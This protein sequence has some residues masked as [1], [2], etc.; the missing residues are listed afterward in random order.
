M[1]SINGTKKKNFNNNKTK[2]N[3]AI[4]ITIMP[5]NDRDD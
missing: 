1:L 2:Q 3:Q 4:L 5:V